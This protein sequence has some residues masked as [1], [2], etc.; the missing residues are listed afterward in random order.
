M[1]LL[2]QIEKICKKI[3]ELPVVQTLIINPRWKKRV[4][5]GVFR[6]TRVEGNKIKIATQ[7]N[8]EQLAP[9]METDNRVAR[10]TLGTYYVKVKAHR[11]KDK[12][13]RSHMRRQALPWRWLNA[14]SRSNVD[15]LSKEIGDAYKD[16][17]AN[18]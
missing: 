6:Y 8:A 1:N 3:G 15:E 10:G 16:V 7:L 14:L 2:S 11:R 9:V 17:I 18:D 12:K 5:P 13:I 4:Y